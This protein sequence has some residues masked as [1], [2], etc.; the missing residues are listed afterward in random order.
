LASYCFPK[1]WP[2]ENREQRARI[3]GE[4]LQTE[5]RFPPQG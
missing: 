1:D 3:I 4:L 5:V 2:A